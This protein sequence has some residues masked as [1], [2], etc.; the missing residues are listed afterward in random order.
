[1]SVGSHQ[2]SP[3]CSFI[4]TL[5]MLGI[6]HKKVLRKNFLIAFKSQVRNQVLWAKEK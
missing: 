5:H 6:F 3:C 4:F 1:M 2:I